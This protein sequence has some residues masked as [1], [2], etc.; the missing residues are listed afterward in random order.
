MPPHNGAQNRGYKKLT[1]YSISLNLYLIPTIYNY[2]ITNFISCHFE[3]L[4]NYDSAKKKVLKATEK[5]R[6][7]L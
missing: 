3:K 6:D 2:L 4:L 7:F 1:L 5:C